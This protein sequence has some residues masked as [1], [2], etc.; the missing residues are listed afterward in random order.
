MQKLYSS[1]LLLLVIS[2]YSQSFAQTQGP[3]NPASATNTSCPFSYSSTVDYLPALNISASDNTYA[4]ASH[5]DCCDQNTRCLEATGFGFAIPVTATIDGIL[6]SVEKRASTNSTVQDNGVRIIKAGVTTGTDQ[7]TSNNWPYVDT[8]V[9][10]G[11]ATNLW[12]TTW[13]P[14]D[15]NAT[16]FGIAIA[17]ISYTCFGNGVPVVSSIDHIRIT[18]YYTDITGAHTVTSQGEGAVTVFPNPGNGVFNVKM[19]N[20]TGQM[21]DGEIK[22]YTI[23]GELV[24]H[25]LISK[26]SNLQIDLSSFAKGVYSLVFVSDT[27]TETKRVVFE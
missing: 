25:Q 8:Y 5:C 20:V 27:V 23:L 14:A 3:N 21:E 7:M 4:T 11:G 1:T 17:S 13:A 12:G 26:S 18:V 19:E 16:N 22:I 10:Y 6:V 9:N 2:F 15:I 24:F